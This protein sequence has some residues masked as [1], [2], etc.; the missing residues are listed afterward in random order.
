[1]STATI[2]PIEVP[3]IVNPITNNFYDELKKFNE[4]VEVTP[5]QNV[6]EFSLCKE[7]VEIE[8]IKGMK[9]KISH[10]DF[11][12]IISEMEIYT[13]TDK[14]SAGGILPPSNIIFI[15]VSNTEILLSCYY[16]GIVRT[17]LYGSNK[18]DIVTPNIIISHTLK[19]DN[20]DWVIYSSKYF[21]T[22]LPISKLPKT[23]INNISHS[24]RVFLLPMTN[25]YDDGK[26]C[27]GGNTMPARYKDNNL[28]GL[29]YYFTFLW[30][31]PF[32]DDLGVKALAQDRGS[33]NAW[34]TLL[35][36]TALKNK[37]FPYSKLSGWVKG[38]YSVVAEET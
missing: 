18:Y 30:N 24:T 31:T 13:S 19:I 4:S 3:S 10:I 5:T 28:R 32:N 12:K 2:P 37:P 23:F 27:Y 8:V 11:R 17:M 7:Y 21:C 25:T 38:D 6:L 35:K 26:M 33:P 20:K 16:P 22:D 29:D 14:I 1:M 9:K 15:S 36:N 34:Y